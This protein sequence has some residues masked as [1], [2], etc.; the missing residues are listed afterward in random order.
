MIGSSKDKAMRDAPSEKILFHFAG[1]GI[2]HPQAIFAKTID[3]ATKIWHETKVLIKKAE[4]ET[5]AP[6]AKVEN[7]PKQPENE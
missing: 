3:E 6:E 7:Q 5:A 2:W 4:G 1:D